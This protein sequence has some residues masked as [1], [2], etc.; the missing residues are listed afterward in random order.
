[1]TSLQGPARQN[2]PDPFADL[3]S[4]LQAMQREM[5][6]MT[7]SLLK[8]AGIRVAPE[9]MTIESGLEVLG[10]LNV[11]GPLSASG[12]LDITGD[13]TF[14]GD[15]TIGGN[16]A[17]TGT[18]SLPAG[19]IDNEALASPLTQRSGY[20]NSSNFGLS[21]VPPD[22][23]LAMFSVTV[24]SGYTKA[25]FIAEGAAGVNNTLGSS[26]YAYLRVFADY[27]GGSSTW[28]TRQNVEVPAGHTRTLSALLVRAVDVPLTGGDVITFYVTAYADAPLPPSTGTF[29][30]A[31]ALVTFT[32]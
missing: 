31:A 18:L 4:R 30:S 10:S 5:S 17:I 25:S 15:T 12:D 14:S 9:G 27:P 13:A 24:P 29:A 6:D 8:S 3:V 1:M 28:G 32:R 16:A 20:G 23:K 26:N 2:S 22:P 19:I 21:D 11:S 7:T